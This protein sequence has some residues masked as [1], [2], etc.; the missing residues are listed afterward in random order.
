MSEQKKSRYVSVCKIKDERFISEAGE[1]IG[2]HV[3]CYLKCK[4]L[5]SYHIRVKIL[6]K[7]DNYFCCEKHVQDVFNLACKTIQEMS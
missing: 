2:H 5:C 4:C 7:Y 1:Y 3:V 6:D